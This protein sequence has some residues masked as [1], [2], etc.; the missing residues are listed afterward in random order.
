MKPSEYADL[1]LEIE[2][3][4]DNFESLGKP[5]PPPTAAKKK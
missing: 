1:T 5:P 3:L 4:K 2:V